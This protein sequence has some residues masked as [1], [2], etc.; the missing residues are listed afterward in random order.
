MMSP[1]PLIVRCVYQVL[2]FRMNACGSYLLVSGS[3]EEPVLFL[4]IP[5][6]VVHLNGGGVCVCVLSGV[7]AR[8]SV[9]AGKV[10]LNK[11]T[12]KVAL[13]LD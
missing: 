5:C 7:L 11:A 4:L 8:D 9:P 13:P 1:V 12:M 10:R 6:V 2:E 3:R